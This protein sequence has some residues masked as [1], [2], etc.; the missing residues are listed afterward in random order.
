MQPPV[1][2]THTID[3]KTKVRDF[4]HAVDRTIVADR[5]ADDALRDGRKNRGD[6]IKKDT[7][8]G[9]AEFASMPSMR[10]R[11][12]INTV[13]YTDGKSGYTDR[14]VINNYTASER[15]QSGIAPDAL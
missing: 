12:G 15:A 5:S 11:G 8:E 13:K 7:K 10:C 6:S 4:T 14:K 1:E 9:G 3:P 2:L